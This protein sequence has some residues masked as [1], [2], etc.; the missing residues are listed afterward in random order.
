[1]EGRQIKEALS[2]PKRD[3]TAQTA[4]CAEPQEW[5][6]EAEIHAQPRNWRSC[7]EG[8]WERA[9]QRHRDGGR[10]TDGHSELHQILPGNTGR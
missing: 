10:C 1:M 6:G 3:A 8:G 7:G 2:E 4:R 5:G 9:R